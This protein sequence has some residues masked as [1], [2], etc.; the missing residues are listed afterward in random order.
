MAAE[1]YGAGKLDLE[2]FNPERY[3]SPRTS[4]RDGSDAR[5]AES[6]LHNLVRLHGTVGQQPNAADPAFESIN[7]NFN[8]LIERIAGASLDE[9]D[10]VVHELQSMREL[11]RSERARV[12]REITAFV[13]LSRSARTAMTVVAGNLDQWKGASPNSAD[14]PKR[15]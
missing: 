8:R 9:I 6:E 11:I 2:K 10:R 7:E 3:V 13:S 5:L 4:D 15:T 14:A 12:S 1:R